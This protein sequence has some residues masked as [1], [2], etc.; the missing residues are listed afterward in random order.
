M[1]MKVIITKKVLH[2]A[3]FWNWEFL[4]LENGLWPKQLLLN[5]V[6]KLDK[7]KALKY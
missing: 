6:H 5:Q 2:L 7:V 3:S 4:E 1:Q